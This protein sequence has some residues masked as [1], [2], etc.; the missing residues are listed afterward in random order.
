M[1]DPLT[2]VPE[3]IWYQDTRMLAA[4][5][6]QYGHHD[7]GPVDERGYRPRRDDDPRTVLVATLVGL[8][9]VAVAVA[10]VVLAVLVH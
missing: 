8:A 5:D 2:T 7:A 3:Y 6:A 4:A 1:S 9:G 10:T